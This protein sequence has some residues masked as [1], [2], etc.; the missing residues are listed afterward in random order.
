MLNRMKIITGLIIALLLFGILQL[1]SGV[2]F[3]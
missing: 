2:F 1:A 3:P